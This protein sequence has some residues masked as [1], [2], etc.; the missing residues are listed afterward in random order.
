MLQDD[1]FDEGV[2]QNRATCC[3]AD[4]GNGLGVL[5]MPTRAKYHDSRPTDGHVDN[6]A[7]HE[8]NSIIHGQHRAKYHDSCP[9][10]DQGDNHAGHEA[11]SDIHGLHA[12]LA[13]I[14]R[15]K[16]T[17]I[18]LSIF[19]YGRGQAPPTLLG[20][21]AGRS[22][23]S[24]WGIASPARDEMPRGVIS[25]QVPRVTNLN[26]FILILSCPWVVGT[27]TLLYLPAF[28]RKSWPYGKEV[29]NLVSQEKDRRW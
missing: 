22:R 13:V 25:R 23:L 6:H 1:G 11:I 28:H 18:G 2:A 26:R 8:V 24:A 19:G 5:M 9:T 14:H 3:N 7:R 16:K 15:E 12:T 17:P 29:K 20:W 4:V 21:P 27:S 10:D